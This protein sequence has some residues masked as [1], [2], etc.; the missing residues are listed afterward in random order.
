MLANQ[1]IASIVHDL[2]DR[3]VPIFMLHRITEHRPSDESGIISDHLRQ[4]LEYLKKN[5]YTFISLEQLILAVNENKSLPSK[6]VCFTMDDGYIDQ[7]QIA[8]PIFLEYDCPITFFVITG[9][10]DQTAWPWDAQISWIIESSKNT[11]I[12]HSDIVGQL[13]INKNEIHNKREFRRAIQD[14][15]KII[16]AEEIPDIVQRLA[17]AAEVTVQV[18]PPADFQPISWDIAHQLENQVFV[19]RH[20]PLPTISCLASVKSL[21]SRKSNNPGKLSVPN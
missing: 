5:N 18:I 1:K 4:C 20:I 2:F 11:S 16:D 7:A 9:M 14:A 19:L 15:I 17:R 8:A 6:S 12:E 21:W 3:G 13:D 10:L